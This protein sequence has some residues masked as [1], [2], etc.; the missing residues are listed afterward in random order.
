MIGARAS[1]VRYFFQGTLEAIHLV[2]RISGL[3]S[4]LEMGPA[5]VI[6]KPV[7]LGKASP[8]AAHGSR[9]AWNTRCCDGQELV[10]NSRKPVSDQF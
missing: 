4:R 10:G 6:D 5:A 7:S 2:G 3:P 9:K 8:A 1:L